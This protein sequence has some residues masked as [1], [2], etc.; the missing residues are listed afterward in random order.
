MIVSGIRGVVPQ[1]TEQRAKR[2]RVLWAI[3]HVADQC[4]QLLPIGRG[5]SRE[6]FIKR[7]ISFDQARSPLFNLVVRKTCLARGA[8]AFGQRMFNRSHIQRTH[9]S[10]DVLTLTPLGLVGC[11]GT[12][13]GERLAQRW[14]QFQGGARRVAQLAELRTQR[15]HALRFALT[16]GLAEIVFA[17]C[18][19]VITKYGNRIAAYE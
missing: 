9:Q 19:N 5:V 8:F 7:L 3:A 17:H 4:A 11:D 6:I 15:F 14:R 1:E 13:I 2:S 10:T 12:E 18:L 16:R